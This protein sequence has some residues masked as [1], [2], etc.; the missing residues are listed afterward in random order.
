MEAVRRASPA[1]E[2]VRQIRAIESAAGES[3]SRDVAIAGETPDSVVT[4]EDITEG[5]QTTEAVG[6]GEPEPPAC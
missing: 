2:E 4:D 1:D 3:S 6:S 5:V